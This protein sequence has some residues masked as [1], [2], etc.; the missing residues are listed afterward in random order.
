MPDRLPDRSASAADFTRA[1]AIFESALDAGP[2]A[3]DRLVRDACG[4]DAALRALVEQMLKADRAPHSLL[5]DGPILASDRWSAG[6]TFLHFRID[7]LIGRGGMGEV[8]RAR[9]LSLDRDVAL[10]VLPEGPAS[11]FG[12]DDRMA[13]LRNEAHTLA[14]LNHPNI[15]TIHGL[16]EADG[17]RA[18]VLEL[19][20]GQTLEERLAG[21]P[22][23]VDEAMRYARQI[24]GALEAAHEQAI[25]HRDLKPSNIKQRSDGTVKLLDFGLARIVRR[26]AGA[27]G[28]GKGPLTGS[29]DDLPSPV[30]GTAA[31][32]SPEQARGRE[33]DR[34]TDIWAFG[35]VLFEMISGERAFGGVDVAETL[36]AVT[37]GGVA[38][39]RLP[40]QTPAPLRLLLERCLDRDANRR[41]RDIGEARILLDDLLDGRATLPAPS[42]PL[43]RPSTIVAAAAGLAAIVALALWSRQSTPP[44]AVT[45][46]AV[47]PPADRQLRV[48]PQSRDLSITRDGTRIIYKGG[49]RI[50][51]TQLFV[52]RLDELEPQPLTPTGLPKAPFVSPDGQWVGFFEPGASGAAFKKVPITGGPA[53]FVSRV[54]GPSRGAVWM[55][56]RTIIAASGAT[57]SGLLRLS[58][59]G[60]EPVVLTRPNR[61]RGEGDHLWPELLPGGR[62]VL[63]TISALSGGIDAAQ[64]GV[65]DLASGSWRSVLPRASQARY[66]SSG[67]LVYVAGGAL[68][69]VPFD[70]TRAETRG[71]AR[72]VV[73]QVLTLSTGVAEFDIADDGTLVYLVGS[74]TSAA[75]RSLVW[76]DRHGREEPID[77]PARAYVNVRLSPDG[78]RVATEIEGGGHDIWVW[79]FGRKSLTQV[80]TD[81]GTDQ[82][83]VWM[84]D[85]RRLVFKTEAGGVLGALAIQA[86]DGSGT[87]ERLTDGA[88]IERASFALADNSRILYSDGSGPKLLQLDP[89]RRVTSLLPQAAGGIGDCQLSPDERWMA[90]V[91]FN[92]DAPQ[93]F[94]SPFPDV[95]AGRTLVTP[96]GGSQPRWARDGRTLFYTSL[97][98][99]LMSV[100]VDS[101]APMTLGPPVEVLKKAYYGGITLLSRLATYDVSAD[102]RFLMLKDIDDAAAAPRTQIVVVRNWIEEL[103]R[104]TAVA[105]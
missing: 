94:V 93:V 20:D 13:R 80:T 95:E 71:P 29:P 40:R 85:G 48:D 31:Y 18:L 3:T 96:A 37:A 46:F 104:L 82:S 5:D 26:V 15:A 25:V 99:T 62:H 50:D 11:R 10:K 100:T 60:G 103:R 21:G 54:D 64:I 74:A 101:K 105:R 88:R 70:P 17:V 73:P 59:S 53:I 36:T 97:D 30:V 81:P 14:A 33:G 44:S 49:A 87:A 35:A 27:D 58:P 55:D 47:R 9:D 7:E 89:G 24:A 57:S 66:V 68:W 91:D 84:P 69:A 28:A 63:F 51:R 75:P 4:A 67:H 41:L 65:L 92:S 45:R 1:R 52:Q 90:Y 102:G 23:P 78:T 72:V 19:V 2:G 12:N 56:D 38:W 83:P 76:V 77:A 39:S 32:M 6:D 22:M 8:Y 42:A 86:A 16:V 34:R 98:G 43:R 79:D 61:E